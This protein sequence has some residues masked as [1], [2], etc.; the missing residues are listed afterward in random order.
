MAAEGPARF[1]GLPAV[2]DQ[3]HVHLVAI[4]LGDERLKDAM[5]VI[6]RAFLSDPAQPHCYAMNVGIYRED[7]VRSRE[8]QDAIGRFVA[9]AMKAK[10]IIA[11][12]VAREIC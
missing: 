7:A 2:L 9:N 3:Q 12:V 5:G 8:E 6:R 1:A 10:E 4:A 11:S